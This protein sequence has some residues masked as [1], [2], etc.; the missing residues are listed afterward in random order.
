MPFVH[1]RDAEAVV[2]AHGADRARQHGGGIEDRHFT[3]EAVHELVVR[4]V[5]VDG[6]AQNAGRLAVRVL[7]DPD[8][9][10]AVGCVAA[11]AETPQGRRV[12]GAHVGD[13]GR[14][15]LDHHRVAI[16]R[17][18]EDRA[19]GEGALGEI[20]IGAAQKIVRLADRR[21]HDPLTGR[22]R[23]GARGDSRDHV[24]VRRGVRDVDER[25]RERPEVQQVRVGV[26]QARKHGRAAQID[27]LRAGAGDAPH[28]L[29]VARPDD[30]AVADDERRHRLAIARGPDAPVQEERRRRH[31]NRSSRGDAR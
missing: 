26:D 14:P 19:V 16:R 30:R 3:E 10:D 28:R 1:R 29:R 17:A 22:H 24:R 11:D 31:L 5:I 18:V 9:R 2:L 6:A 21:R 27:D 13:D 25:I 7:F 15:R 20:A 8:V 12:E 23:R 4:V